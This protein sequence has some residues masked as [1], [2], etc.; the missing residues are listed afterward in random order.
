MVC[1]VQ[2]N[3]LNV[4]TG[5]AFQAALAAAAMNGED[6]TILLGAGTYM[7]GF[8]YESDESYSLTIRAENGSEVK[9]DGG[10]LV[11]VLYLDAGDNSVDFRIEDIIFQYG[12]S[13]ESDENSAALYL[14]TS[15]DINV[16]GCTFTNNLSAM[17]RLIYVDSA[18]TID[19]VRNC[20]AKNGSGIEV[21]SSNTASFNNNYFME[22]GFGVYVTSSETINFIN[23]NV[24][25]CDN[26][27]F[28][29]ETI[30]L[31]KNTIS[32]RSNSTLSSKGTITLTD[33]HISKNSSLLVNSADTVT[34]TNN[35]IT[36]NLENGTRITSANTVALINNII[37]AN[38]TDMDT[39]GGVFIEAS[40]TITLANNVITDNS[41]TYG[42]G[43]HAICNRL[44]LTNNTI[45][46]NSATTGG[47]GIYF[48]LNST[49][50][51]ADICNNIIWGNKT[52]GS[53][54]DIYIFGYGGTK[55]R[56]QQQLPYND[57][58]MGFFR[59]PY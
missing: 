3:V 29:S 47:G 58:A 59:Q 52:E 19:F 56:L 48:S 2:A 39:G 54:D 57:R 38:S 37:T 36:G 17:V 49:E 23:N 8:K 20:I 26:S 18:N 24:T 31:T 40:D 53:G 51:Q 9:M 16:S 4:D 50:G 7:G 15:G 42:G 27:S 12:N 55:K 33:N 30:I 6:D 45:S 44:Y 41:A 14:K 1:S 34:L 11:C 28:D 46:G 22:N 10:G 13:S 5:Q 43:V 21:A 25:N 32:E 35:N